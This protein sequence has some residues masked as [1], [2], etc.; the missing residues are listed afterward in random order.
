MERRCYFLVGDKFKGF[1]EGKEVLTLNQ[2][3][4]LASLPKELMNICA[5]L[6]LGQGVREED[7]RSIL[8]KYEEGEDCVPF[9]ELSDLHRVKDRA[10]GNLSHKKLPYNTLIGVPRRLS[11]EEFMIPLNIDERCELMGDHQTGQHVQGM[12]VIEAFRQS[13][14]AV[15]ETFFPLQSEQTYFVINAMNTTFMNFLFPLP[16]DVEYRIVDRRRK[17]LHA[18]YNVIMSVVQNDVA[19]AT[20]DVS[21]TVYPASRIASKEAELARQVT[22]E[23]L[24]AQQEVVRSFQPESDG[25]QLVE[26]NR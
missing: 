18:R 11:D 16:A 26:L 22:Q 19:C 4:A 7:V 2:L 5:V 15:T 25:T 23:M 12:I 8:S 9:L 17:G 14:L 24:G 6:K 13:F 20:A 1:A 3:Q 21:F 10:D